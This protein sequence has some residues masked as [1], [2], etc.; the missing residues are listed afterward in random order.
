MCRNV[1]GA[2]NQAQPSDVTHQTATLHITLRVH[3]TLAAGSVPTKLSFV[4]NIAD[5]VTVTPR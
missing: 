3:G 5:T 4:V 2:I 1:P